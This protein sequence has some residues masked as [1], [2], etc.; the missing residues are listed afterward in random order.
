MRADE[1]AS[2]LRRVRTIRGDGTVNPREVMA[3]VTAD[4]T[5]F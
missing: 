1:T 5:R 2:G 4:P 3:D